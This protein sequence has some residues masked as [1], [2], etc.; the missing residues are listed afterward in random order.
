MGQPA[1]S[2]VL[3]DVLG[4]LNPSRVVLMQFS[5]TEVIMLGMFLLA[6]LTYLNKRK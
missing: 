3:V 1:T 5:L 4:Q 2:A 6:M